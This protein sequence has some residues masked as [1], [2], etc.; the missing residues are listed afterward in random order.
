MDGD[1]GFLSKTIYW[2]FSFR[3]EDVGGGSTRCVWMGYVLAHVVHDVLHGWEGEN[4]DMMVRLRPC[5]VS[6]NV[7]Q[8]TGLVLPAYL[9]TWCDMTETHMWW[10]L[11]GRSTRLDVNVQ[12]D[13]RTRPCL[14]LLRE[15]WISSVSLLIGW[16]ED[17]TG[18]R[19]WHSSYIHGQ[20]GC[21]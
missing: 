4:Y 8:G 15:Q 12:H 9:H 10:R 1:A 19:E 18:G 5:L 14:L 2:I 20:C 3:R 6:L 16:G 21:K 13:M 7:Y 11:C 17:G